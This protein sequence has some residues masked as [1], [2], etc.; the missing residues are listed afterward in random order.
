MPIWTAWW[1]HVGLPAGVSIWFG[2][3]VEYYNPD[4][5][6]PS[7]GAAI[8]SWWGAN[9]RRGVKVRFIST[10]QQA[11]VPDSL[12]GATNIYNHTT[13]GRGWLRLGRF[14]EPRACHR[15]GAPIRM[16]PLIRASVFYEKADNLAGGM[17]LNAS[18]HGVVLARKGATVINYKADSLCHLH[19]G[20]TGTDNLVRVW[21][22]LTVTT[23]PCGAPEYAHR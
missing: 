5:T 18:T 13:G 14:G 16:P 10:R 9:G 19:S 12:F 20:G 8:P 4:P 22:S 7:T 21:P 23:L 11:T 3:D 15:W 17:D 6:D 2:V 1:H